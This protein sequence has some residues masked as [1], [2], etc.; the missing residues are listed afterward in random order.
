[1]SAE[2][3]LCGF[4]QKLNGSTKFQFNFGLVIS[5]SLGQT[6][7]PMKTL[8][9]PV[10]I[11]LVGIVGAT[12]VTV[13]LRAQTPTPPAP[14]MTEFDRH[15][16]LKIKSEHSYKT[17]EKSFDAALD[18]LPA[19]ALFRIKKKDNLGNEQMKQSKGASLNTVNVTNLAAAQSGATEEY[20][21]IGTNVTQQV[22]SNDV[23]DIIAVLN[24][25]K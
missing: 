1:L 11:A 18:G 2:V 25:L 12:A 13:L 6:G 4:R 20:T 22:A 15:F 14:T 17:D 9:M 23:G 10:K 19:T 7:T 5:S 21:V 24:Q 8:P 3:W 16:V